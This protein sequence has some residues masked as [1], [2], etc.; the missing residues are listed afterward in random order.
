MHEI[1]PEEIEEENDGKEDGGYPDQ[2]S[3]GAF[4]V[5]C[6]GLPIKR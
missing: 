6:K 5:F 2:F 1:V 4:H 3:K